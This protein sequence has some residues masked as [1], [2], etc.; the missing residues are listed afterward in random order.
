MTSD[1]WFLH[2]TEVWKEAKT[3]ARRMHK[4]FLPASSKG[5][6]WRTESIAL[7]IYVAENLEGFFNEDLAFAVGMYVSM[8]NRS[9]GSERLRA[10]HGENAVI[11][12]FSL[13]EYIFQVLRE[14]LG[15]NLARDR[16]MFDDLKNLSVYD[17]DFVPHPSGAEKVIYSPKSAAD[18]RQA[19]R[20]L[21]DNTR[22]MMLDKRARAIRKQIRREYADIG[23]AETVI[24]NYKTPHV[25]RLRDVRDTVIHI[26]HLGAPMR[27]GNDSPMPVLPGD[28]S[29]MINSPLVAEKE[30]C[31][32]LRKN[33]RSLKD[34]I[35][36]LQQAI[37]D[38]D[39]PSPKSLAGRQFVLAHFPCPAC[40][41]EF[42]IPTEILGILSADNSPLIC[43]L[44]G[45][46]FPIP[47]E[48]ES[49]DTNHFV[50]FELLED[51]PKR[52]RKARNLPG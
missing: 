3:I 1:D 38:E 34:S 31:D 13:W 11:R 39:L 36:S 12:V 41:R 26:H 52:Y 6:A 7:S 49:F 29:M 18:S 14:W 20:R 48:Y 45:Y 15:L 28:M 5:G 40:R 46:D 43:P 35:A 24:N 19:L 33:V 2:D 25:A 44:C 47:G 17:L 27:F 22:Y 23:F 4:D 32:L 37:F 8:V 30:L 50:Y 21:A 10:Y 16:Q 9:S 42:N 51:Y